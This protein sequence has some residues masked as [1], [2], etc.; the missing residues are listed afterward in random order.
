VIRVY[1]LAAAIIPPA[2]IAIAIAMPNRAA[3]YAQLPPP[4]PLTAPRAAPSGPAQLAAPVQPQGLPSLT[5]LQALP[6]AAPSPS[7]RVFNCSCYGPGNGAHWAG[8]VASRGYF[9]ARQRAAGA[10][11]AYNQSKAPEPPLLPPTNAA[12]ILSGVAGVPSLPLGQ[13]SDAAGLLANNYP[14]TLN[15]SIPGQQQMCSICTCD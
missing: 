11:L 12:Q 8:Q 7:A 1:R 4:N 6:T 15:F 14:G 3:V 2:L 9:G 13:T 10:C 5:I